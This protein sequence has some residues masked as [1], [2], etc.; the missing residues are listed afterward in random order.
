MRT[1][2]CLLLESQNKK[3]KFGMKP[4]FVQDPK[5][6]MKRETEH[7]K[8]GG[9]PQQKEINDLKRRAS[10]KEENGQGY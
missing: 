5:R 6:G 2:N 4:E 9:G 8:S 7:T 10:A 1:E 3:E